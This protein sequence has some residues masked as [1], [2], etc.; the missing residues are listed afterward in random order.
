MAK[1]RLIVDHVNEISVVRFA[2]RRILDEV[3]LD[4]IADELFALIDHQDNRKI[5][6]NFADVDYLSGTA[7]GSLVNFREKLYAQE[8]EIAVCGLSARIEELFTVTKYDK[9]FNIFPDPDSAL[10]SFQ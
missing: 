2:D 9:I 1:K 7:L 3:I 6:L 4:A 10:A 5:L 8:G